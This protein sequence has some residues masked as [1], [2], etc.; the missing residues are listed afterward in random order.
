M[1]DDVVVGEADGRG[2]GGGE[3]A[4]AGVVVGFDVGVEQGSVRVGEVIEE[5]RAMAGD[6]GALGRGGR[7]LSRGEAARKRRFST[8]RGGGGKAAC[9]GLGGDGAEIIEEKG[10]TVVGCNLDLEWTGRELVERGEAVGLW[11]VDA[12]LALLGRGLGP[13]G[14]DVAS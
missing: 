2:V 12:R 5:G 14:L 7:G 1:V 6:G 13:G 11:V 10:R 3:V 4:V 8:G 9:L